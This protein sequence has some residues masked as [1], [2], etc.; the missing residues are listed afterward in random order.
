MSK[1]NI[2]AIRLVYTKSLENNLVN[3]FTFNFQQLSKK[4]QPEYTNENKGSE[5]LQSWFDDKI[6][7]SRFFAMLTNI[8][9][10]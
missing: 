5:L 4:P 7:S 1:N 2:F 6:G 10:F 9:T 3:R 8:T